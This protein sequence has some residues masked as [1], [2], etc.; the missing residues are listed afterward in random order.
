MDLVTQVALPLVKALGSTLDSRLRANEAHLSSEDVLDRFEEQ[1]PQLFINEWISK[2]VSKP[3]SGYA[4]GE[5]LD[6]TGS[7]LKT[8]GTLLGASFASS[9][10]SWLIVRGIFGGNRAVGTLTS[11]PL[12]A[13]ES[14]LRATAEGIDPANP[15]VAIAALQLIDDTDLTPEEFYIKERLLA[16]LEKMYP[17]QT[18]DRLTKLLASG[19]S[20][21][22]GYKRNGDSIGYG[23]LW[24]F[25][26][27]LG[28]GL[29]L[30]QGFA[31]PAP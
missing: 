23:L 6:D 14:K 22:H 9:A 4:L 5:I 31:K 8:A 2:S 30:A 3:L 24:A 28:L 20:A 17:A 19:A 15:Y 13:T 26:G 10:L 27:R 21:Y 25:T 12:P 1:L 16:I 18:L 7:D 11:L 29:A